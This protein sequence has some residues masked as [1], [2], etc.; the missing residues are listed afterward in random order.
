M[1]DNRKVNWGV[2]ASGG[3]ARKFAASAK[4]TQNA[5]LVAVASRTP[6]KAKTFALENGV[7]KSY[8]SYEALLD[9]STIDAVYVAN[10]HNFH[11]Q[12]VL[13]ALNSSKAVLCEKPLAINAKQAAEMI[14]AA[15]AKG[16]FL[17]EGMWTRFLP[18]VAQM[19]RWIAGGLIGKPRQLFA[20]FGT[21]VPFAPDHR[22]L[23]PKLAG[24]AL[25]DL[26]IYPL[27][28]ASMV[29]G[30]K[31]PT[32]QHSIC[33]IGETGVDVED[34]LLL[35]YPCGLVAHLCCGIK[36]KYTNSATLCGETGSI[37]LPPLFIG[38]QSVTLQTGNETITKE[39]PCEFLH[40]FRYEIEAA[41][42]CILKGLT[43]CDTI[44][45]DETLELARTMD[46]FR[47]EWGLRYDGE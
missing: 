12:T 25:L 24:G 4:T 43:E 19:R 47:E 45:L 29:A 36:S 33:E 28:L 10:T 3:I 31:P 35:S 23:N 22:M 46:A 41:S 44:P 40:G 7:G 8:D 17:M 14:D 34:S 5:E 1:P 13:L 21:N 16:V 32:L 6:G 11:H 18:A 37:T 30:G 42:E 39:F 2:L 27:A 20:S 38:A 15:R 9:D 26:G